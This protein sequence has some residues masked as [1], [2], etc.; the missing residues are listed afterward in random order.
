MLW[1]VVKHV[2]ALAEGCEVGVPVVGGTVVPV[3]GRQHHPRGPHG[4]EYVVSSNCQAHYPPCAIAPK[5]RLSVPPAAVAEMPE[6][7]L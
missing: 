1:R 4:P 5:G 3:G 6:V 2:A 7:C